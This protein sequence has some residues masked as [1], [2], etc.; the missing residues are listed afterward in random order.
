MDL[1][2]NMRKSTTL[3]P[4]T[5]RDPQ[6]GLRRLIDRAPE[7]EQFAEQTIDRLRPGLNWMHRFRRRLA[8]GAVAAISAWLFVHVMFG[9]NGMVVYRQKKSE[10]V[11]LQKEIGGLQKESDHYSAEIEALKSDPKKIIKVAREDLGYTK[12]GEIVF[13][14]PHAAPP[15]ASPRSDAARK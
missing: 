14:Q 15:P 13:V 11:A 6:E 4:Q 1:R 10:Y 9:A 2:L 8:T 7:A 12:P 3:G 5:L